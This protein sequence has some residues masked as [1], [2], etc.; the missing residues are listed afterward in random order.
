V[1]ICAKK[2]ALWRVILYFMVKLLTGLYRVF[3]LVVLCVIAFYARLIYQRMPMTL[4]EWSET[5]Q[6][7]AI[8]RALVSNRMPVVR[9]PDEVD[10]NIPRD[11]DVNV[12]NDTLDV[13]VQNEVTVSGAVSIEH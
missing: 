7:P 12:T 6:N 5:S 2:F 10:V 11:V 13:N 4:G 8:R 9:I 1:E 3:L